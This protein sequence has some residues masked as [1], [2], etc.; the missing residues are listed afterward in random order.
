MT[1]ELREKIKPLSDETIK[2]AIRLGLK[3]LEGGKSFSEV[4]EITVDDVMAELQ[5][6]QIDTLEQLEKLMILERCDPDVMQYF[7]DFYWID[8]V[9]WQELKKLAEGK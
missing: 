3:S 1:D 7:Q 6:S 9:A 5:A 2:E 8:R 4:L